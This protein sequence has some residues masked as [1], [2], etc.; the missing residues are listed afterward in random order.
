[1]V[2]ILVN[3]STCPNPRAVEMQSSNPH[4]STFTASSAILSSSPLHYMEEKRSVSLPEAAEDT[5]LNL[6]L[7]IQGSKP[8][9]NIP[10]LN[11]LND[12]QISTNP[13]DGGGAL[14]SICMMKPYEE[15]AY[16][17]PANKEMPLVCNDQH[18]SCLTLKDQ[19][20]HVEI[21]ATISNANDVNNNEPAR[22]F[23]CYFCSR[24]FYS[25]QAL[26]G[27][28][29]AHKRERSAVRKTTLL[30]PNNPPFNHLQRYPNSILNNQISSPSLSY[31]NSEITQRSLGIKAH[32]L[33]HK[34]AAC[35]AGNLY[36]VTQ[37]AFPN[38]SI[39]SYRPMIGVGKFEGSDGFLGKLM[40]R[41]SLIDEEDQ[42]RHTWLSESSVNWCR[43]S[44][45]STSQSG[46]DM[47]IGNKINQ[48]AARTMINSKSTHFPNEDA[49]TSLDLSLRL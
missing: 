2:S 41:S 7:S 48:A 24:K 45:R 47:E 11:Q 27:H 36:S 8:G 26:G 39:N 46:D 28:Q 30:P 12:M 25:S 35:K 33:I 43:L 1:M 49:P 34:P 18:G 38:S 4:S 15:W 42:D 23:S 21:T 40:P 14:P 32:S 5:H 22:I 16:P 29:N 6:A 37:L 17:A 20:H 31:G 19:G 3:D 10:S 13:R 9:N 44:T